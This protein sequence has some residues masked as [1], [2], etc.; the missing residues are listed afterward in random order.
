M[1]WIRE[2]MPESGNKYYNTTSNGGY[3]NCI[4][5]Y[6]SGYEDGYPGLN[7][8]PNCVGQAWGAFNETWY[9]NDPTNHPL[10][11][12][13]RPYGDANTNITGAKNLGLETL[14][15]SATPPLGGLIVWGGSANH[16]AYIKEVKDK[17][18]IVVSQ[19][20]YNTA[21]WVWIERTYTRNQNGKTNGW[22]Y[23][24]TDSSATCL[25]FIVNPGVKDKPVYTPPVINSVAQLDATTVQITGV[26]N[27]VSGITT[28][29]DLYIKWNSSTASV[30]NYD[31]KKSCSGSFS[32]TITKPR[33]ASSIAILPVQ[34]NTTGVSIDGSIK[35]S[36]L[37]RSI[38]CFNVCKD[39]KMRQG[40]PYIFM[41]NQWRTGIIYIYTNG[42][43]KAIYNNEI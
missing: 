15:A 21:S 43:W 34:I 39:S 12:F 4:V 14:S 28:S 30:S 13:T 17:D 27:G 25:G 23:H 41:G 40:I 6:A 18:T 5:G 20:G 1:A 35:V 31:L 16:V 24:S 26:M 9:H 22:G 3:S 2:T 7:V 10:G 11:K 38:S 36:T 29:V 42:E 32:V 37:T 8:L 33:L 19:S